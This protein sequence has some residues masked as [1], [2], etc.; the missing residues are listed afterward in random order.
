VSRVAFGGVTIEVLTT[1]TKT[2]S[3]LHGSKMMAPTEKFQ[4]LIDRLAEAEHL[5][6]ELMPEPKKKRPHKSGDKL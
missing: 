2:C 3:R 4:K 1:F 6:S 5:Y